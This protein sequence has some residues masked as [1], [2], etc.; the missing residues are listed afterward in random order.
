[1]EMPTRPALLEYADGN[2]M[3]LTLSPVAA[4]AMSDVID[5]I[6]DLVIAGTEPEPEPAA[7]AS[8]KRSERT[9]KERPRS[10]PAKK[11]KLPTLPTE[12]PKAP[13]NGRTKSKGKKG[14]NNA[15]AR[16]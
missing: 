14:G 13:A 3:P 7:I 5:V 12:S 4:E 1:M 16:H 10:R 11:P 2:D 6:P 9:R 15:K 8:K